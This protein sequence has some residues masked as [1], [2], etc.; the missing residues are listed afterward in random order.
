MS[1][2][3]PVMEELELFFQ[4]SVSQFWQN[5]MKWNAKKQTNMKLWLYNL[6]KLN[7]KNHSNLEKVAGFW[8]CNTKQEEVLNSL[9]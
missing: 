1:K 5:E 4:C 7:F 2:F 8:H 3:T 9:C 6:N